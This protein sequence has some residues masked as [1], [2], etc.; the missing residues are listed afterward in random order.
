MLFRDY[1]RSLTGMAG[2]D[3][4]GSDRGCL[5]KDAHGSRQR[6]SL[7]IGWQKCGSSCRHILGKRRQYHGD[8][9][10]GASGLPP[11]AE[12]SKV[13]PDTLIKPFTNPKS[14]QVIV[15]GGNIQTT[16]FDY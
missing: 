8:D 1:M 14:I 12:W 10:N 9:A 3:H 2:H 11:Y 13:P 4:N 6:L 16:W 15:A 7:A 5:L